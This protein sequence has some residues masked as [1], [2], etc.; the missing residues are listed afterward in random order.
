MEIQIDVGTWIDVYE[1]E[2][3][4]QLE[5]SDSNGNGITLTID[6]KKMFRTKWAKIF[7]EDIVK[8]D[9]KVKDKEK[10]KEKEDEN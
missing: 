4:L 5:T 8:L 2:N 6:K 7:K 1:D 10:E 9:T 3:I